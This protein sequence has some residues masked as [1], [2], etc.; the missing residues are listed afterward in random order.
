MR[1]RYFLYLL[2][3]PLA[4]ALFPYLQRA[5]RAAVPIMR[6]SV[7]P[8]PLYPPPVLQPPPRYLWQRAPSRHPPITAAYF[9]C[10]GDL[11]HPIQELKGGE[12]RR[13]CEGTHS[14]P[15]RDGKEFIYPI[16]I[17]LL[18][19]LQE[20]SGCRAVITSGHR[21]PTHHQYVAPSPYHRASKHMIGAEVRFYLKG[22]EAM[23][24]R[25]IALLQEYY[26]ADEESYSQFKRWEKEERDT[27]IAPW[28]NKELFIKLYQ[29]HE[30]RDGDTAHPYPYLALQVRYDRSRNEPVTYSWER[31]Q[32]C[33]YR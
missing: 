3:F 5:P 31:A 23:P 7:D 9:R 25:V 15:L 21:C 30:G 18:N 2:L 4:V 22:W 28:Y 10:R 24:E 13:D 8:A 27:E 19:Y 26:A 20:R 14:L 12:I 6:R 32:S 11:L 17:D 16:L 33:F 29:S 1:K